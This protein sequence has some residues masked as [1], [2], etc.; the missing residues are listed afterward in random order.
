MSERRLQTSVSTQLL[1]IVFVLYCLIALLVTTVH[2]VEEYRYTRETIQ[3]EL[4]S[5]QNIFGPV[6]GKAL[7]D[8]DREQIRDIATGLFQ[9]PVIVGVKIEKVQNGKTEFIDGLGLTDT[10]AG[11]GVEVLQNDLFSYQF[12]ITFD[13]YGQTQQLGLATIYSNSDIVLKRVKL[14]FVFLLVNALI[15][16]VALWVIF[17]WVSK[18]LLLRPLTRFTESIANL[19]FNN[20]SE[21]KIDIGTDRNNE[22]KLIET[23]FTKMVRELAESRKEIV[24]FNANLEQE[25]IKR[26]EELVAAKEE[27]EKASTAKSEF[28]ATVSHE[29]RTPM[30][31]VLGMLS[32][33]RKTGLNED[34]LRK[35][36]VASSSGKSL[37]ALINDILDFSKIDAGKLE[38]DIQ[39]F[40]LRDV[41]SDVVDSIAPAAEAK[42]I[43]LIAD[44]VKVRNP[45]V[46]GDPLRLRQILLNLASNAI[47]FTA[48]GE[49]V[50]TAGMEA[51]D[52][53]RYRLICSVKDTGIGIPE[54]KRG[55]L[56]NEFVQVDSSTTRKYGG[57]GLGLAIVK[58]LCHLMDGDIEVA[59][60]VGKGSEFKFSICLNKGL[61]I[62]HTIP[63]VDAHLLTILIVDDNST[64]REVLRGQ[65]EDWGASVVEAESASKALECLRSREARGKKCF[66]LAILDMEMPLMN[67]V[68]LA[69]T[70]KSDSRFNSLK[71]VMMTSVGEAGD[72][73]HFASLGF[74]AYF[75]KPANID[76]LIDALALVSAKDALREGEHPLITS[77]YVRSLKYLEGKEDPGEVRFPESLRVLVVEDNEVNREVVLGLLEENEL[78]VDSVENGEQAIRR[79]ENYETD[80]PYGMVIMDCQMP[81]LDGFAATRAIRN[82][83]VDH[84]YRD[85]PVIAMTANAGSAAREECLASGMNDFLTKPVDYGELI[86]AIR[87]WQ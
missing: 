65:L 30:N 14:G 63:D 40:N 56:F 33:L 81:T 79:L 41:V 55:T 45:V 15:K 11:D 84:R 20:L 82:G 52:D 21:A 42:N 66:D 7:W 51:L 39:E 23:T 71:L 3:N 37:L 80:S 85:I 60:T 2:V 26:T 12:P 64:N 18:R 53:L 28:L 44:L 74:S 17:L 35:V 27:A 19:N 78:K 54:D 38:L 86:A 4:Q 57:T 36:D 83:E 68:E 16:G 32:L 76:N 62:G 72:I 49:I 46:R 69:R 48:S 58:K 31:G 70:I 87:R 29:I 59:S 34:Q 77:H 9:V 61:S 10:A 67:G 75:S 73:G 8:L 6:L 22:I 24:E 1:R 50:I 25:V 47:K 5:Y 13:I 43:E